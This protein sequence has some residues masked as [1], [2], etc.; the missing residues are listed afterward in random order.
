MMCIYHSQSPISLICVAPHKCLRKLC[1]ECLYEHGVD[2]KLTIP[3][4]KFKEL[5]TKKLQEHELNGISELK[6]LREGFKILISQTETIIKKFW[7]DVK[8]L[9][10]SIFDNI[11]KENQSFI[12]LINQNEN[13]AE[14]S[15]TDLNNIVQ[16]FEGNI[17]DDWNKQK[18]SY[19]INMMQIKNW[20]EQGANTISQNFKEKIK[21]VMK[22]FKIQKD[23]SLEWQ[24]SI[25]EYEGIVWD[26]N[27]IASIK[28]VKFQVIQTK[29][30]EIQYVMNRL[31]LRKDQIQDTINKPEILINLEQI[32]HLNWIGDYGK[33]NQKIGKWTATWK[34]LILS[35]VGGYYSNEGKKQGKWIEIFQNYCEFVQVYEVGDYVDGFKKGT[36][37]YIYEDEKIGGGEY[38][39][40]GKK[41]GKWIELGNE[42]YKYFKLTYNGRY[43]NGIKVGIWETCL[44]EQGILY[45]HNYISMQYQQIINS[46][47]Q[48]WWFI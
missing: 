22:I 45:G 27:S 38:N 26:Q 40:Q 2:V 44:A 21:E 39:K 47:F 36:W 16:I 12:N 31:L 11:E 46:P 7:E 1:V 35:D 42:F 28:R 30:K 20:I 9:I 18:N 10:K 25:T 24:E 37:K 4:C 29:E 6:K 8:E 48:R 17:L 3:I 32:Q 13:L 5:I 41:N 23:E 15:Y 43:Q 19:L 14:S 33:Q 34:G